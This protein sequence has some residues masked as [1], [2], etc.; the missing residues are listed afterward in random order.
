MEENSIINYRREAIF[1]GRCR[2]E[3]RGVGGQTD[4]QVQKKSFGIR[5]Y[6]GGAGQISI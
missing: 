3:K 1:Y 2:Q 6:S 4:F 5:N